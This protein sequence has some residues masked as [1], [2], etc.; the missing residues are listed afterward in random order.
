MCK[1]RN[2]LDEIKKALQAVWRGESYVS[3]QLAG[4]LRPK[5]TIETNDYD[6]ELIKQ[7]ANGLNQD[8]ISAYFKEHKIKLSSLS[9]IEKHLQKLRTRFLAKN[10]TQLVANAKDLGVI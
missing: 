4:A 7:L 5:T 10:A 2:G 6:V 9:T 3:P 8:E 1:G